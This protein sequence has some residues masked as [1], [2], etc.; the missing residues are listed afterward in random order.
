MRSFT[1][2]A[3]VWALRKF[4]GPP[5]PPPSSDPF[6]LVLWENIAYLA[7]PAQRR[8]AFELL[9][10]TV[11]TAPADILAATPKALE[12]VT[13]RGILKSTFA[14]KLH[15]CARIAL[16]EFNG[17]LGELIREPLESAKRG[18]RCF[19][20]IGEPGAE[21]ILLLTGRHALLAPD[22]NALR[23]LTRLGFVREQASY[24]RTYRASRE[25]AKGLTADPFA[26]Q[27]AHALLQQHGQSL[28]KRS[29]P[30]CA[31]CPLASHCAYARKKR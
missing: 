13:A 4:Y 3:A 5:P 2:A 30:R 6:E 14:A 19:P 26:M 18:L 22:S 7:T 29:A 10:R 27:E 16:E 9:K 23:V 8:A 17:D 15:E 21:K 11:G 12:A 25:A 20:G 28:C 31:S 24:A 1:L